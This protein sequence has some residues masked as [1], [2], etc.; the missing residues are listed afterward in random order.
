MK[1]V[2][3]L[4]EFYNLY[5]TDPSSVKL[6]DLNWMKKNANN[7]IQRCKEYNIDYKAILRKDLGDEKKL[8]ELLKFY[9]VE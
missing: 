9:G 7:I 8:N 5:K 1:R 4:E 6:E 3:Q 2:K